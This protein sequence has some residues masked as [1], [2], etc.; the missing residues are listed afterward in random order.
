MSPDVDIAPIA[1]LSMCTGTGGLERGLNRIV[2]HSRVVAYV[3]IEA[4]IITNLVAQMEAGLLDPA[5]VWTN[6]KTFPFDPFRGRVDCFVAGYPCQPF[7]NTGKRGGSTDPRHLWP[8]IDRGINLVR[9]GCCWFENVPGHLTLGFDEVCADLCRLGYRVEAGIFAAEE[10]G[11]T[12]LRKRLFILAM[13][14]TGIE[15]FRPF[16]QRVAYA[17]S[18]PWNTTYITRETGGQSEGCGIKLANSDGTEWGSI[19][20]VEYS[21]DTRKNLIQ[22]NGA[23]NASRFSERGKAVADTYSIDVNRS[24]EQRTGGRSESSDSS[25][26][27]AHPNNPGLQK[28]SIKRAGPETFATPEHDG[29]MVHPQGA[30]QSYIRLWTRQPEIQGLAPASYWPARPGERQHEWEEPRTIKPGLGCTIN[31]YNFKED[32][33]RMYGN[34]VVPDQAAFAFYTLLNRFYTSM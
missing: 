18:E 17:A 16:W 10:I 5:P 25:K 8:F 24:R 32:L 22:E 6:L 7:S 27:M 23:Q 3:E 19:D 4:F 31:G 1:T 21:L 30:R 14:Y 13:D 29:F 15:R 9:P 28:R 26:G 20:G 33:L 2:G 34:G 11:A 12:H